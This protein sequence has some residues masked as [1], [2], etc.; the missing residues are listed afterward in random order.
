MRWSIGPVEVISLIVFIGYAVTYSL[1]IA[2]RYSSPEAIP[3]Q[4]EETEQPKN[5]A[6]RRRRVV[7]ALRS[8]GG[9][10]VG[11]AITTGGCAC[12]LMAAKLTLFGKLGSVVLVVTLL[13]VL[14][15]L[16]PLP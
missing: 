13:S 4:P 12:F 9:A 15:A 7:F 2:H 6:V 11:S 16:G 14:T 10:T 8:I 1:H 3:D 5:E